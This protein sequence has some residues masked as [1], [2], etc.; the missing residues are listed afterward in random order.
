[1]TRYSWGTNDKGQL[2]VEGITDS[3]RPHMIVAL[4][5]KQ[6]TSITCGTSHTLAIIDLVACVWGTGDQGQ[7]GLGPV[8]KAA[9]PVVL[10]ELYVGY[11]LCAWV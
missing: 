4:R 1:L 8:T 2:G 11:I 5:G 7:L 3:P 9:T 10:E 6:V